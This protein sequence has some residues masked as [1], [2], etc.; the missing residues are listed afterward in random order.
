[1]T[2]SRASAWG[3]ARAC[4]AYAATSRAT[5]LVSRATRPDRL[6]SARTFRPVLPTQGAMAPIA[7]RAATVV[8]ATVLVPVPSIP[9]TRCAARHLVR[10]W[11]RT[12]REPATARVLAGIPESRIAHPIFAPAA[13]ACRTVQP[14]S[15][16]RP[17]IN[18]I[19]RAVVAGVVALGKTDNLVRIPANASRASAWTASVVK[20]PAPAPASHATCL[21]RLANA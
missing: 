5:S 3:P 4:S 8:C 6:A 16:A 19:C 18:A 2:V 17:I 12:H 21:A 13:S 7:P 11:S 9:R 14:T 15:T 20:T 1:M 10:D